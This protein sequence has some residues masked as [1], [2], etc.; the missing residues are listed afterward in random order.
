MYHYPW[1]KGL[2][3]LFPIASMHQMHQQFNSNSSNRPYACKIS[4]WIQILK[5]QTLGHLW[6]IPS[7]H[8]EAK[9]NYSK[10]KV[11]IT[12]EINP[13]TGINETAKMPCHF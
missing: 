3:P 9:N 11:V 6:F 1:F 10:E 8:L 7:H 4:C 2:R 13:T 12:N 5:L